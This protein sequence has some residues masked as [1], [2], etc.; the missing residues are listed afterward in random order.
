MTITARLA[1]MFRRRPER[2]ANPTRSRTSALDGL[3]EANV[4]KA[5]I[6]L[7]PEEAVNPQRMVIGVSTC[8]LFDLEE[9]YDVSA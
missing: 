3:A 2:P 7:T 1:A 9:E 6:C 8:V 4:A 5:S